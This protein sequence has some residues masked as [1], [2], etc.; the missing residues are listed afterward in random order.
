[1]SIQPK[2]VKKA[3]LIAKKSGTQLAGAGDPCYWPLGTGI[4]AC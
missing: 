2:K 3:A 4:I 1:M